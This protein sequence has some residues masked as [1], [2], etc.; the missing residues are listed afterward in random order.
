MRAI[1]S[2]PPPST[3]RF[4]ANAALICLKSHQASC[5]RLQTAAAALNHLRSE[6]SSITPQNTARNTQY[7]PP[8][9]AIDTG[10]VSTHASTRLRTVAHCK[11][12]PVRGHRAG[13]AGRQHVSRRHRQTVH[14]GRANRHHRNQFGGRA[15]SVRQMLLADFLADSHDD[16]LPSGPSCPGP[17]Q[18]RPRP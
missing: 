10:S 18:W 15:L 5:R 16:P 13:H 9:G 14:V 4:G 6:R 11:P 17:A 1:D 12:E 7:N 2:S 3:H 8:R